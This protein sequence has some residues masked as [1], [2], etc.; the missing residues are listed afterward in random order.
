MVFAYREHTSVT[1]GV[2][3]LTSCSEE[4]YKKHVRDLDCPEET[5]VSNQSNAL[6]AE[7]CT[8]EG[9]ALTGLKPPP[10]ESFDSYVDSGV[11]FSHR[12]EDP[13]SPFSLSGEVWNLIWTGDSHVTQN[14]IIPHEESRAIETTVLQP[15]AQ[16]SNPCNPISEHRES[17]S[18]PG[19]EPQHSSHNH[20]QD[21]DTAAI[22]R[23]ASQNAIKRYFA[24]NAAGA[25]R[26]S[27]RPTALTR[28][29][30]ELFTFDDREDP[31][32]GLNT[33]PQAVSTDLRMSP[34]HA[35]LVRDMCAT[36]DVT[37]YQSLCTPPSFSIESP[38]ELSF[39]YPEDDSPP[40]DIEQWAFTESTSSIVEELAKRLVYD[41]TEW[42]TRCYS[43]HELCQVQS[44][45]SET[46]E[47]SAS[48]SN[49]TKQGSKASQTTI[50]SSI[51]VNTRKRRHE[52]DGD[53]E[54]NRKRRSAGI[55]A[56]PE[57][58]P[59]K[60]LACPYSK[61]DPVRYSDQNLTE[62]S[63]R[64]CSRRVFKDISRLKQH[65]YRVHLPPRYCCDRCFMILGNEALLKE[66]RRTEPSCQLAPPQFTE[67]MN[68]E[69]ATSVKRRFPGKNPQDCWYGI[70]KILF[71]EA[72][73]PESPYVE[74]YN[75]DAV[76]QFVTYAE[77][78]GVALL[79]GILSQQYQFSGLI[80]PFEQQVV[81]EAIEQALPQVLQQLAQNFASTCS[82]ANLPQSSTDNTISFTEVGQNSQETDYTFG[83]YASTIPGDLSLLPS[84]F[85]LQDGGD[86]GFFPDIIKHPLHRDRSRQRD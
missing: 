68:T 12:F 70:F 48:S 84:S 77:S 27:Y 4:M 82:Q 51:S 83:A 74:A 64:G 3:H 30:E 69:Q 33:R 16:K 21:L 85:T 80:G 50:P 17:D 81:T 65:L 61:L 8:W 23:P 49:T 2:C 39:V 18:A 75:T 62:T 60:F 22:I 20:P 58:L 44:A 9:H 36:D 43:I 10:S 52:D 34:K 35:L 15:P 26:D 29:D 32:H 14:V 7:S 38:G 54:E 28:Q 25:T 5:T 78:H 46:P 40:P 31:W 71:P 59:A 55:Q 63:Y 24:Q 6:S 47:P 41:Y 1:S 66:H 13:T 76:Q 42:M 86:D 11:G 37:K 19:G 67:R 53:D 56:P 72:P 73:A 45:L 79:N 57:T